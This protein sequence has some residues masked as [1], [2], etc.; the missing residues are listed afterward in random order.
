ML[1]AERQ[2]GTSGCDAPSRPRPASSCRCRV[3][4]Q[5]LFARALAY[6]NIRS[7]ICIVGA[8]GP[9]LSTTAAPDEEKNVEAKK[10]ESEESDDDMGFGLFD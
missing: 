2:E 1:G 8:D 6:V 7:L 4:S 10:E 3:G 5:G 9:I